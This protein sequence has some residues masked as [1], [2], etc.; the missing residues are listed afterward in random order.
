MKTVTFILIASLFLFGCNQKKTGGV[1]ELINDDIRVTGDE[2]EPM[3]DNNRDTVEVH[4]TPLAESEGLR[5]HIDREVAES[6]KMYASDG[7]V[8][9]RLFTTMGKF[10]TDSEPVEYTNYMNGKPKYAYFD[11]V[12][13]GGKHMLVWFVDGISGVAKRLFISEQTV[14]QYKITDDGSMICVF[15]EPGIDDNSSQFR[16]YET[17]TMQLVKELFYE[18]YRGK[19]IMVLDWKY[20]DGIF[21]VTIGQPRYTAYATLEIPIFE[22]GYKVL[23]TF[24]EE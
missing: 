5:Y 10:R 3:Q 1:E 12:T 14:I 21:T 9:R 13:P 7:E 24:A 4:F 16:I 19:G 6:L 11:Y 20:Q 8:Q 18:P 23:K 15:E 22:E 17:K 2:L